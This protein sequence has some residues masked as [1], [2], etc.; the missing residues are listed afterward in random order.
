MTKN[1]RS[2]ALKGG[3]WIFAGTFG[4]NL[5]QFLSFIILARLLTPDEF[6]VVSVALVIIGFLKIFTELGVGPAVVQRLNL[7]VKHIRTAN[8]LSIVLGMLVAIG[9]YF[10]AVR[11]SVFF[12]MPA[13]A[14]VV[15]LLS[16]TLPISALAVVGQSLLQRQLEFKRVAAYGFVSFF[17]GY[18]CVA[19]PMA[20]KGYGVWSLVFAQLSQ[21]FIMMIT[22]HFTVKESNLYGFCFR[23]AKELLNFGLGYSI[24]NIFSFFA[25]EGDNLIVGKFL[26]EKALGVYSNAYRL[27]SFPA[28]LIGGVIDKVLFPI[29]SSIQ[30]DKE[31]LARTYLQVLSFAMMIILPLTIYLYFFSPEIIR[32]LL[33]PQ[34]D[35]AIVV[36]QILIL[37]LVFRLNYKFSDLLAR[38]VGAV[39]RRALRQ[40]I[41]A[42]AVIVG[43][44]FGQFYGITGVAIGIGIA[45]M[46]N[47]LLMLQ[48][49]QSLIRF[50]WK[51]VFNLHV[52]QLGVATPLVFLGFLFRV[53]TQDILINDFL[54]LVFSSVVFLVG[55]LVLWFLFEKKLQDE[56]DVFKF[57]LNRIV[58]KK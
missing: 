5:L 47:Y 33:G 20:L 48:L 22:I 10:S 58:N 26:S 24:A 46:I 32:L 2:K 35:D 31:R 39:Y 40:V 55:T 30:E 23:S 36:F 6:G 41:Y 44:Y 42:A 56:I 27:M 49:S 18:T 51:T 37:A 3:G 11:I 29:F 25:V 21:V 17:V 16:F 52:K 7:T 57:L 12:E 15:R 4:Q 43:G 13:L 54:I 9:L 45:I 8:T 19:I 34:W 38:A 1:L 14:D 53:I 50:S 28:M